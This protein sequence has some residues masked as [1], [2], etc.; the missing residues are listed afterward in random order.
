MTYFIRHDGQDYGAWEADTAENALLACLTDADRT[1]LYGVEL[2]SNSENYGAGDG[3][4]WGNG[5]EDRSAFWYVAHEG[6]VSVYRAFDLD[7]PANAL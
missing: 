2:L 6:L 7:G 5:A 3:R 1:R 4:S